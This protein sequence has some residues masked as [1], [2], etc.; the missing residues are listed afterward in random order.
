MKPIAVGLIAVAASLA[1]ASGVQARFRPCDHRAL[2]IHEAHYWLGPS[3]QGM[4]V[5]N[6]S[7]PCRPPDRF[8]S[9]F[10]MVSYIY[11]DCDLPV[12]EEAPS[13]EPPIEIQS[14]RACER[15]YSGT[16]VPRGVR[17]GPTVRL[18]RQTVRGVP[19][20]VL[21]PTFIELYTGRTTVRVFANTPELAQAAVASL[22]R[23]PDAPLEGTPPPNLPAPVAGALS[24]R[25]RCTPL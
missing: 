24:G 17:G 13:C 23:A 20:V 3:F 14:W 15:S 22:V 10:N 4:P 25:L 2:A 16:R 7:R 21:A 12:D 11:G 8:E 19:A 18:P 6:A 1:F 5:T 9:G